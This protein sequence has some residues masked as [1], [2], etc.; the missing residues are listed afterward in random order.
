MSAWNDFLWPLSPLPLLIGF[1]VVNRR[2]V[3]DVRVSGVKG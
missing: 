1:L 3:E 2:I